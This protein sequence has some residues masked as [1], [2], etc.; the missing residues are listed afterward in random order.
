MQN[1]ADFNLSEGGQLS[2]EYPVNENETKLFEELKLYKHFS[3]FK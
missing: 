1:L 3:I 2:P